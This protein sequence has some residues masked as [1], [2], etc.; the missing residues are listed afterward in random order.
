MSFAVTNVRFSLNLLNIAYKV[1]ELGA[2][3]HTDVAPALD[4]GKCRGSLNG[5]FILG[6]ELLVPNGEFAT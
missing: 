3:L 2:H 1:L 4:G 5:R 6:T